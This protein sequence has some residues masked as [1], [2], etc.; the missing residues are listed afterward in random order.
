MLWST[1]SEARLDVIK[2]NL[3]NA[4]LHRYPTANPLPAMPFGNRKKNV[5]EDLPS[6]VLSLFKKI[7]PLWK[8]EIQ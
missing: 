2:V 8:P 3:T 6:S 1:Y 5:L 7:S 4:V